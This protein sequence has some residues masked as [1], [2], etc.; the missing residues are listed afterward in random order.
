MLEPIKNSHLIC[1]IIFTGGNGIVVP[2]IPVNVVL[3][4][5]PLKWLIVNSCGLTLVVFLHGGPSPLMLG[6]KKSAS[7]LP[8]HTGKESTSDAGDLGSIP[9]QEASHM[10]LS[11]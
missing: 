11:C 8:W 6:I 3:N 4:H 2:L 1:L 7:G 10:S 5:W 9:Y